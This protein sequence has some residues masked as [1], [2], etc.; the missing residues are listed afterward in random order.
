[1]RGGGGKG[2]APQT[3]MAMAMATRTSKSDS[4]DEELTTTILHVHCTRVFALLY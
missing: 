1:V 2:G 3:P 4:F